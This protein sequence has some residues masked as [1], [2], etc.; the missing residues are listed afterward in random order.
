VVANVHVD[1]LPGGKGTK[2]AWDNVSTSSE[3]LGYVVATHQ[4]RG[5]AGG[6]S[7]LSWYLPLS[8]E[9]PAAARKRMLT[10]PL[11]DWQALVQRDLLAMHPEL[12]DHIRRIDI[13]HWG[14]GM[15]RPTPGFISRTAPAARDRVQPPLFLA[16]SDLGGLS[17][18]E[19]AHYR[20]VVAAEAAM[21]HLSMPYESL[22]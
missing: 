18:F 14:H 15:I 11:A 8:R 10:T 17:L 19:E 1:Q 22:I 3:A 4:S 9:D 20:G 5:S 16:H 6:G 21:S 12:A 7:V 2:L 13:W